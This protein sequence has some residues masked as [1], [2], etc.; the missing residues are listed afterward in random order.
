LE[1]EEVVL[2]EHVD[3]KWLTTEELSTLDW[4]AADVPVVEF[5]S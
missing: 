1:G 5:L 4:A 3:M 2:N